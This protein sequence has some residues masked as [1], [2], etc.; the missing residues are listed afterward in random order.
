MPPA[1]T[2]ETVSVELPAMTDRQKQFV[3][4]LGEDGINRVGAAVFDYID[5]WQKGSHQQRSEFRTRCQD[6]S[7]LDSDAVR[8]LEA[9]LDDVDR[10]HNR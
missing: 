7:D 5:L 1:G 9:R 3:A 10:W 6:L 8:Y 2:A 4:R